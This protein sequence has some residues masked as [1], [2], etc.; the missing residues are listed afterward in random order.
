M[1]PKKELS[2]KEHD[3][4]LKKYYDELSLHDKLYSVLGFARQP[5]SREFALDLSGIKYD[6]LNEPDKKQVDSIFSK[7]DVI[8][9]TNE[10]T[11]KY[12]LEENSRKKLAEDPKLKEAVN[13]IM[14]KELWSNFED[15]LGSL[16][17][18]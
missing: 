16:D 2:Q 18:S 4:T 1:E 8:M 3:E 15:I 5:I 7:E 14:A 10:G 9:S 11:Q 12:W 6:Q 13:F 17:E